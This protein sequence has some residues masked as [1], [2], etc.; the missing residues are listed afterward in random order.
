MAQRLL[1][2]FKQRF[3]KLGMPRKVYGQIVRAEECEFAA[4][5]ADRT[6]MR[7]HRNVL[8]EFKKHIE[9]N[10]VGENFTQWIEDPLPEPVKVELPTRTHKLSDGEP[11]S[12]R[13]DEKNAQVSAVNYFLEGEAPT[14][15][16]VGVQTGKGKGI[17]SMFS[18]SGLGMRV[19]ITV[20][21][22][23]VDKWRDEL[24]DILNIDVMDIMIVRK[25][26][27]LKA[28]TQ[29][30]EQGELDCKIVIIPSSLMRGWMTTYE[31]LGDSISD[32]GY[33]FSPEVFMEKTGCGVRVVDEVHREF[34]N[35]F[36]MDLYTHCHHIWSMSATLRTKD[37]FLARMFEIGY[38]SNWRFKGLAYDK[39]VNYTALTYRFD[40]A[41]K[42]RWVERGR[43]EYS[44]NVFEESILKQPQVLRNYLNM[45]NWV[46]QAKHFKR[47]ESGERCII[48][49]ASVEMCGA[50]AGYL[51]ELYPHL[52]I[53][54]YAPSDGDPKENL[55]DSDMAVTT[56]GAGGTGHD[57]KNLITA[58]MTTAIDSEAANLQAMGRLRKLSS[59]KTPEFVYYVNADNE[60]HL[61]YHEN[62][63]KLLDG[64]ALHLMAMPYPPML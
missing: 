40:R 19:M 42:I 25:G 51:Q 49:A 17:I 64:V 29:L 30:C 36:K 31:A 27:H 33:E 15:K 63:T 26:E 3:I 32:I 35:F 62:K 5:R 1:V 56:I 2:Q 57:I 11:L 9:W 50:M 58:I 22:Q 41:D 28:L 45:L 38:P 14:T 7:F 46:L 53:R 39:Y 12:L 23:F 43:S 34:H 47:Y 48:F 44:H 10:R 52:D 60:K 16:L 4:K 18:L 54:R 55:L 21:P 20:L 37:P 6:E 13:E 59:G 8:Q 24:V 61:K